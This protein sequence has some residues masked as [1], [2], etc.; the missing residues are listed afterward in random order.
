MKTFPFYR[1]H[2]AIIETKMFAK[3]VETAVNK[4]S[5]QD[6]LII[7]TADHSHV[8]TFGGY[9]LKGTDPLGMFTI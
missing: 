2:S 9:N 1:A 3:A 4:T 7:V 8:M 6:T 5:D